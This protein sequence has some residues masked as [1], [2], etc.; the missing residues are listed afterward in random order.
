MVRFSFV[1]LFLLVVNSIQYAQ[2]TVKGI[3]KDAS[4]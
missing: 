3:V 4:N 1:L 2:S